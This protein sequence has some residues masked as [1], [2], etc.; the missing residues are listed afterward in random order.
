VSDWSLREKR[1]LW[2]EKFKAPQ[3]GGLRFGQFQDFL[4]ATVYKYLYAFSGTRIGRIEP[5]ATSESQTSRSKFTQ[6]Q[7]RQLFATFDSNA[8]GLI[9]IAEFE[10]LCLNWILK[11]F[12][13]SCALVVVDVQNDFIDG[14]LALINGPA[15]QD[16]VDVVPVI[17]E[18]LETCSFEAVVY[19]QDWHPL[20]HIGFHDNLHL[21]KYTLK[22]EQQ[23]CPG[24]PS[25]NGTSDTNSD[26]CVAASRRFR[27]SRLMGRAN[28]FDTVLFDEGK[29]EQKLW[30]VHCVQNSWG[31]ELHPNLKIVPNSIRILKGTRSEI[32]AYS[33]FWDNM[34][35]CETGLRQELNTRDINDVFVCGLALDYCVAASALD[36]VKAG[37]LTFVIEDACR[38]IDTHEM[39]LRKREM[40]ESGIVFVH[41]SFVP[42]YIDHFKAINLDST[43]RC[44]SNTNLT[45]K[46]AEPKPLTTSTTSSAL[47]SEFLADICLKRALLLGNLR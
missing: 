3:E 8:D 18:L 45:N 15:H 16:G 28:L 13:R 1:Q 33:A 38:G 32:D 4:T 47:S 22:R 23:G 26:G 30:P 11:V 35:L 12:H 9:D 24:K 7:E 29:T 40:S 5:V 2:F 34:R 42:Q 27:P 19:T 36:A 25:C 46:H 14:S 43:H 41:S 21:R 20:D 6:E 10:Y 31:A 17:N 37:F 39:E 44:D